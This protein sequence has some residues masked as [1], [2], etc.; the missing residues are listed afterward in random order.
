VNNQS[1]FGGRPRAPQQGLQMKARVKWFNPEKGFGF[2]APIDGSGDAFIHVSAL[3][4]FGVATLPEGVEILCEVGS[5]P[6]G[7]QVIRIIDAD[8]SSI[9]APAPRPVPSGGDSQL[10]GAVKWFAPEKGFGF[11]TA[12]DG[13]KDIFIHKSVLRGCGITSLAEGQRVQVVASSTG[14]GREATWIALG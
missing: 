10:S 11:I 6:K 3:Q 2:V 12:D 1:S 4:R 13:G 8:M 7:P 14:K 9:P 5:G